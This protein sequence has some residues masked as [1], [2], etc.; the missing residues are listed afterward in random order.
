MPFNFDLIERYKKLGVEHTTLI[1]GEPTLHPQLLD[2]IS[3]FSDAEISC[4]I[5]SNGIRFD[6]QNFV[7]LIVKTGVSAVSISLLGPTEKIHDDL[8]QNNGSFKK[9]INGINN[10]INY[11]IKVNVLTT[12]NELN[13]HY[14][15][16]IILLSDSFDVE[17]HSFNICT[18]TL[19]DPQGQLTITPKKAIEII[20]RIYK[21]LG[22]VKTKLRIT[23]PLPLCIFDSNKILKYMEKN[24]IS[25]NSICQV[26]TGKAFAVHL[27][28]KIYPCTHITNLPMG[29]IFDLN[30]KN[31]IEYWNNG[32][33]LEIR[34][35]F[36]KY[37]SV[38]CVKCDK[39]GN[40][41]G[42]CPLMWL[43]YDPRNV[44]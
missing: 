34:K 43:K 17:F 37:P 9:A 22:E 38:K 28:G 29:N 1:G 26:F 18:P 16:K 10:L 32:Y 35:K 40:C 11:D 14:L 36:W 24:I 3:R 7:K 5:V 8:T 42:G 13:E 20:E 33:P 21:M 27:D 19:D 6:D 2:I 23:T 31:Y 4:G 39:W 41:V 12:I 30:M 44:I 15:E 25:P